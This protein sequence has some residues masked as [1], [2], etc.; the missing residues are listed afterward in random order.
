MHGDDRTTPATPGSN[1]SQVLQVCAQRCDECLFSANALV[2]P[3]TRREILQRVRTAPIP[4][5]VAPTLPEGAAGSYFQCHKFTFAARDGHI[6]PAEAHVMC[7]GYYD[8]NHNDLTIPIFLLALLLQNGVFVD[9]AGRAISGPG[10][11]KLTEAERGPTMRD[12]LQLD[13]ADA[14]EQANE[15]A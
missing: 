9:E 7:R 5:E 4:E 14:A 13:R 12:Q 8:A 1:R 10:L 2:T 11:E 6:D 15:A 3:D